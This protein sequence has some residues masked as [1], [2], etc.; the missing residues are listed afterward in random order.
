MFDKVLD[1]KTIQ[2]S[3]ISGVVFFLLSNQ[4][5]LKFVEDLLK[6]FLNIR[7]NGNA[8]LLLHSVVF[9][10]LV[11][12]ISFYVYQPLRPHL[13]GLFR[14]EEGQNMRGG[15]DEGMMRR[16]DGEC[17]AD[18]NFDP[19]AAQQDDLAVN[20][21]PK[22]TSPGMPCVMKDDNIPG[23]GNEQCMDGEMCSGSMCRP[24]PNMMGSP[25]QQVPMLQQ[26]PPAMP[27]TT[28]P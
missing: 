16:D 11:G 19:T 15:C 10:L 22:N 17:V 8:L 23:S 21:L 12:V 1:E 2:V 5:V 25:Q 3:I 7:L 20:A 6:K 27:A 24:D 13:R 4:P 14:L 26:Q 9:A 28:T 18:P